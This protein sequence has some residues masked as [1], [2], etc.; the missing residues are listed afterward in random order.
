MKRILILGHT[1]KIGSSLMNILSKYNP[2]GKNSS[3]FDAIDF[4]QVKKILI[5]EKP[6]IVINCIAKMGF[7]E[8]KPIEMYMINSL[9]PRLLAQLSNKMNFILIHFST[10]AV[11]EDSKEYI[12]ESIKPKPKNMYSITK[13]NGDLF[14]E[15]ISKKYY[16][17]RIPLVFGINKKNMLEHARFVENIVYRI[18]NGEKTIKVAYNTLYS[19]SYSMDIAK[20]VKEIIEKNYPYG[21]Y[22]IANEG[23]VSLYEFS[24]ELFNSLYPDIRIIPV[25]MSEITTQERNLFTPITSEKLE[26]MRNWREAL[27][28]Y[29]KE[30]EKI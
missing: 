12:T 15:N 18:K 24:Q 13:Y 29:I 16:I 9:F 30:Y 20:K 23:K 4:K 7:N 26:I 28:D 14:I 6:N 22:H 2:I 27:K 1:G 8:K 11:L 3:D 19:P 25:N 17:I 21:L 5:K 10:D